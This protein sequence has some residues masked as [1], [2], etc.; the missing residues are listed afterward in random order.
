M[1]FDTDFHD[2]AHKGRH[3]TVVD[4]SPSRSRPLMLRSGCI[5][6]S[7]QITLGCSVDRGFC[8]TSV[9]THTHNIVGTGSVKAQPQ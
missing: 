8:T 7:R 1:S 3:Q 5:N 2:G 6:L 4:R 9:L